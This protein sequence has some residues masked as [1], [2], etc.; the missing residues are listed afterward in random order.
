MGKAV[1]AIAC[2]EAVPRAHVTLER[3]DEPSIS[4]YALKLIR[5]DILTARLK[6]NSKLRL[7]VLASRYGVGFNPLREA[8][9]ILAGTGPK[10]GTQNALDLSEIGFGPH[11]T[12]HLENISGNLAALSI[13]DGTHTTAVPLVG[14]VTAS[15]NH[16][17]S[18]IPDA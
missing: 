13:A 14:I 2:S 8:L 16:G 6:P 10:F 4:A 5:A 18:L 9:A 1:G 15:D 17:T 12:N 7:K 3:F 11:S